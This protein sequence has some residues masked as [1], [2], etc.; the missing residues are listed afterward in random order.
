[1][2]HALQV[3]LI[4]GLGD[5]YGPDDFRLQGAMSCV[6]AS[7]NDPIFINHHGKIDFILEEWLVK[8]KDRLSYPLSDEIREGHRGK[9]GYIVPFI[10]LYTHEDMFKTADN[11]GYKYLESG[12]GST[13]E[14]DTD[15]TPGTTDGT[16]TTEWGERGLGVSIHSGYSI[17]ILCLTLIVVAF[18]EGF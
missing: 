17:L 1:M 7:P 12:G 9:D 6:A 18:M 10:P 14:P 4:L 2:Y 3:H 15:G 16:P 13:D 5:K 8:N 11:F